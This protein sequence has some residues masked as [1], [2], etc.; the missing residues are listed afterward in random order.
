MPKT[1]TARR[2]ATVALASALIGPAASAG[3]QAPAPYDDAGYWRF[4]DQMQQRLESTWNPHADIYASGGG[5]TATMV[6]ASMLLTHAVAALHDHQG[7][8]RQDARARLIARKVVEAPA[9]VMRPVGHHSE[10]R[11]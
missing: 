7:P 3:A 2:L 5:G 8:S 10:V 4:T 11:G 9:F 1:S 6:N